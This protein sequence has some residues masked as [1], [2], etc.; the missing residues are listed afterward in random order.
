MESENFGME[1]GDEEQA[2]R[3]DTQEDRVSKDLCGEEGDEMEI[4]EE[5]EESSPIKK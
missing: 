2:P 4:G 5:S 3:M 1:M